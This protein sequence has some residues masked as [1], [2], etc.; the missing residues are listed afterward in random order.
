MGHYPNDH[1]D[2]EFTQNWGSPSCHE[3]MRAARQMYMPLENAINIDCSL[4]D[5]CASRWTITGLRIRQALGQRVSTLASAVCAC[6]QEKRAD[7]C[8]IEHKGLN[9]G[10]Q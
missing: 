9:S 2:M 8:L 10:F 1:Q 3:E 5:V 6:K 7:V 4:R